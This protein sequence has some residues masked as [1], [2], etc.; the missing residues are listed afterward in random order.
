LLSKGTPNIVLVKTSIYISEGVYGLYGMRRILVFL[1]GFFVFSFWNLFTLQSFGQVPPFDEYLWIMVY[2]DGGIGIQLLTSLKEPV[3]ANLNVLNLQLL[4]HI[5]SISLKIKYNS[6]CSLQITLDWKS[7]D[8]EEAEVVGYE[9][10]ERIS[11]KFLGGKFVLDKKEP[12][13]NPLTGERLYIRLYYVPV[14][15]NFNRVVDSIWSEI[16][17]KC[18]CP[19][20]LINIISK[21]YLYKESNVILIVDDLAKSPSSLFPDYYVSISI[22]FYEY[23]DFKIGYTYVLDVFKLFNLTNPIMI[24]KNS[25]SSVIEIHI[26]TFIPSKGHHFDFFY[27]ILDVYFSSIRYRIGTGEFEGNIVELVISNNI[28]NRE[29]TPA[30]YIPGKVIDGLW[31][32]FK[33]VERGYKFEFSSTMYGI[34]FIS[35]SMVISSLIV[36]LYF[37]KKFRK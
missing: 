23:F 32:K 4:K 36:Y 29:Q 3:F 11:Y 28:P 10:V 18:R 16:T 19:D 14:D 24:S 13:I 2:G 35:L 12:L 33:V 8:L 27:E 7:V 30:Y 21:E 37:R 1:F 5:K 25:L 15:V 9:I 26:S 6:I 20:G 17:S 34:I 22:M 31:V